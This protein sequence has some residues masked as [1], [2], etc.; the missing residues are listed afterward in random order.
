M[1][2][3]SLHIAILPGDGIGPE[4]VAEGVKVLEAVAHQFNLDFRF[5]SYLIGGQALRVSEVPLPEETLNGVLQ[6][7]AVLLG[8]VGS[9]EFD[10]NPPQLKPETA[11][12]QLRKKLEAF[13]NLRPVVLHESLIGVS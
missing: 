4:V 8:A 11:L 3:K 6:S 12:L 2:K 7:D 5:N 13:A 10:K 9:P 1:E